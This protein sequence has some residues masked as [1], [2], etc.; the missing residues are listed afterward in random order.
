MALAAVMLAYFIYAYILQT[1]NVAAP[2]IAADLNG[3]ALYSWSVSIPSLGLAMGTLLAGKFS[4]IFGRRAI[5]I[6]STIISLLSTVLCAIS[7]TFLALIGARTLLCLGMGAIAPLCF[8]VVGDLFVG[9]ERS[10]WVGLLNIPFAIPS[11]FGPTLSGWMV[12]KLTWHHIFWWILPLIFVCILIAYGMPALIM[13]RDHKIDVLGIILVTIASSTLIFGLS[14]A[15]TTY[16]WG[17]VQVISLLALSL[18]TWILFI[19]YESKTEGPILDPEVFKNRTFLTASAAG[20]FSFFGMM[21]VTLYYPLLMQGIQGLSAMTS[22]QIITPFSALMALVGV[23]TGYILARTKSYK[24]MYVVGYGMLTAVMGSMIFFG[25]NTPILWGV[26]VSILGGIGQGTIPTLNTVVIQA[27]V[28]RRLLGIATGA[29]FFSIA[30][31][32]A[33]APAILG[34][35][36]NTRYNSALQATLPSELSQVADEATMTSLGNPRVLLSE[37]A[38]KSLQEILLKKDN[39]AALLDQT[40]RAIRT[41]MEAGLRAVFFI[42]ALT[43]LLAFLLIVT[44]PKVS[45]EP[46]EE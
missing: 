6:A 13:S 11:L 1:W 37:P 34:S 42:A 9:G 30:M 32:M 35:A 20:F 14:F 44:I 41:S 43:M 18:I 12:D 39:G 16:P 38:M 22:G 31:G 45:L 25:A 27:A 28:P 40:I 7:P 29:L 33:I 15:G 23:P 5:L 2:K 3:M 19:R 36:M 24:W 4:D 46:G 10:K 26:I 21:G 17:S 8:A